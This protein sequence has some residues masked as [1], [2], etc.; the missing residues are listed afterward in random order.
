MDEQKAAADK[1][2]TDATKAVSD[3]KAALAAADEAVQADAQGKVDAAEAALTEAKADREA[4]DTNVDDIIDDAQRPG[5]LKDGTPADKPITIPKDKF[6]DLNE[7][8][9]LLDQFSPVLA[10]LKDNPELLERLMAGDD[11]NKSIADRLKALED[12]A[13][14]DKREEIRNTITSAQK[15][16]PDFKDRWAEIKPI[17]AGLTASGLPYQ[18]AVQRAYFA[19]N[20]DAI[21]K[22]E[23]LVK[24]EKARGR[25]NDRGRM[26]PGGGAGAPVVGADDDSGY[27]LSDADMEFAKATGIDPKLY[28]KHAEHI[29]RFAGL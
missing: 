20:P 18:E 7:K 15:T 1:K 27:V 12:A 26:A 16:W 4:L 14:N 6:D 28:G 8:A 23:R 22:G 9:K 11:P 17:L 2:V 10:K 24:L 19:V 29:S 25:E 5:S 3:A 21:A 13:L